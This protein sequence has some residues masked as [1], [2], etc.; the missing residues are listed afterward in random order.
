MLL[1][2]KYNSI[3]AYTIILTLFCYNIDLS[4]NEV[5][6]NNEVLVY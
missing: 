5:H 4:V 6:E 3:Q 2:D 1:Y